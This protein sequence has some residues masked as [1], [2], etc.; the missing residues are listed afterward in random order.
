ML[1]AHGWYLDLEMP[2]PGLWELKKALSEGKTEEA[3]DAL[4]ILL[5]EVIETF[6]VDFRLQEPGLFNGQILRPIIASSDFRARRLVLRER[7]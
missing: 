6:R 3:E 5:E 2:L 1:G 7:V 4:V